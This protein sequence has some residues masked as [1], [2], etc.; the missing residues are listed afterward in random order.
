MKSGGNLFVIY[1]WQEYMKFISSFLNDK[2]V[3]VGC[4]TLAILC[5]LALMFHFFQ[6]QGDK[7]HQAVAAKSFINGE[8]ISLATVSGD[9]LSVVKHKPLTAWPPW[10]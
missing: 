9:N 10:L 8:G 7:M 4:L 3:T 1:F 2:R 5:K 6:F